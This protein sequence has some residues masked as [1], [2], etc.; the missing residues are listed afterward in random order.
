MMMVVFTREN[1]KMG[2]GVE[3]ELV[4]QRME[5]YIKGVGNLTFQMVKELK[6]FL[7]ETCK[8]KKIAMSSY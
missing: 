8:R 7:M 2:S 3:L 4:F 6:F 5:L 1:F